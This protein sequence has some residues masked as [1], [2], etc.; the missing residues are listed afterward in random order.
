MQV[1]IAG[2]KGESQQSFCQQVAPEMLS[3]RSLCRRLAEGSLNFI[4]SR[5]SQKIIQFP[6]VPRFEW[7]ILCDFSWEQEIRFLKLVVLHKV[8]ILF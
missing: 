8:F 4:R 6:T 2:Q 5:F 3:C 7:H 1:L